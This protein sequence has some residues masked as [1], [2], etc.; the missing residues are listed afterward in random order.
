MASRQKKEQAGRRMEIGGRRAEGRKLRAATPSNLPAG[1]PADVQE[2]NPDALPPSAG[3]EG[4]PPSLER[5]RS[6][7]A[8]REGMGHPSTSSGQVG[9]RA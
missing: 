7:G 3:T 2:E 6:F 5:C 9:Q 4:S 8:P 1:S